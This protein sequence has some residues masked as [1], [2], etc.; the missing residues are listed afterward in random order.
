M[1]MVGLDLGKHKSHV[2]I[3]A[4]DGRIVFNKKIKTTH[5]ALTEVF[6]RYEKCRVLVES[7]TSSEWVARALEGMGHEVIVADPNFGPM[8]AQRDKK[9]KSDE[10]DARALLEALKLNAYHRAVRRS[11]EEL[12]VKTLLNARTGLVRSRTKFLSY[13]RSVLQRFG[14]EHCEDT[15]RDTLADS[16]RR[17]CKDERLLVLLEPIFVVLD[18]ISRQIKLLD[19]RL[20]V[21]ADKN[22]VVRLLEGAPGVGKL[23]ALAFVHALSDVKR[24]DNANRVAAYLGLIPSM[25]ASGDM[26]KR[27]GITKRGDRAARTLLHGSALAIM[28]SKDPDAQPLQRWA[29][30][31]SRRRGGKKNGGN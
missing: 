30:E 31:L 22:P 25:K 19:E 3:E 10:R 26:E 6:G 12:V 9:Q 27:G 29:L 7:S 15:S 13:T 20:E 21:E 11:D 18:E 1:M 2:V 8:Y 17:N 28:A 14:Y 16:L 5:A 24:F 4:E 23:T